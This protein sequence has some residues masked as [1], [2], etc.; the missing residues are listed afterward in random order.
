M[1]PLLA[2]LHKR[3]AHEGVPSLTRQ[4][5]DL[6]ALATA[7]HAEQQA[8]AIRAIEGYRAAIMVRTRHPVRSIWDKRP[9]SRSADR[10]ASKTGE[11]A[12]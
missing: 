8:A 1:N 10:G 9:G 3:Y 2:E 6:V 12:E 7:H 5:T 11:R 4:T